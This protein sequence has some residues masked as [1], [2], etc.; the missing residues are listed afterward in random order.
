VRVAL[1]FPAGGTRDPRQLLPFRAQ[2]PNRI[3]LTAVSR[4]L[5]ARGKRKNARVHRRARARARLEGTLLPGARIRPPSSSLAPSALATS[6]HSSVT[7]GRFYRHSN[8]SRECSF[9]VAPL[10]RRSVPARSASR[11][12]STFDDVKSEHV[13]KRHRQIDF[14]VAPIAR[15]R[16]QTLMQQCSMSPMSLASLRRTSVGKFIRSVVASITRAVVKSLHK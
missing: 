12:P 3:A 10:L 8:I 15:S 2:L 4:S 11:S 9:D 7:L 13:S 16:E 5:R 1:E 14:T 6:A